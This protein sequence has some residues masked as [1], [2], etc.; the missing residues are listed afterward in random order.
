MLCF[1]HADVR[2]AP[3]T[4][5]RMT[6]LLSRR[7]AALVRGFPQRETVTTLEWLLLPLIHFLLLGYL[8][9][10]GLRYTR[11]AGFGAGCGQLLLVRRDA[12][13]VCGDSQHHV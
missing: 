5:A 9:I 7:R 10:L 2:L 13:E 11:L 1:V 8:P 3:E 6:T 12:C 4:V